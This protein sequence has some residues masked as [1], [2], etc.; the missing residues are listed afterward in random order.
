[1][2]W[3]SREDKLPPPSFFALL[4]AHLQEAY[5]NARISRELMTELRPYFIE[6]W[7]SGKTAEAAAQTTCSCNGREIVPSPAIGVRIAKGAVR[8]PLGAVRG[9][10][11]GAEELRDPVPVE[12]LQKRLARVIR[13]QAQ[14]HTTESKWEQRART[15]RKDTTRREAERKQ[16]GATSRYTELT[17]EAVRIGDEIRRLRN[18]LSRTPAKEKVAP[19][20]AAVI[21]PPTI[22]PPQPIAPLPPKEPE[23]TVK[24]RPGRKNAAAVAAPT[25]PVPADGE[26]VALLSAIQGLLPTIANQ[27]AAQMEKDEGGT[28]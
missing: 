21:V 25:E 16:A 19:A 24:K 20:P 18:E 28:K 14:V 15:A 27:L 5:P 3:K 1:M 13:E 22:P 26:S 4:T 2:A 9:T 23:P 8:P 17:T 6:A 12:R 10:V 7:R 11:F